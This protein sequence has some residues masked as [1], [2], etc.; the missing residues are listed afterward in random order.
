LYMIMFNEL[1][2]AESIMVSQLLLVALGV[3]FMIEVR[4]I[5][6]ELQKI[7]KV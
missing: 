7:P 4:R 2:T 6:M 5:R 3:W 1:T